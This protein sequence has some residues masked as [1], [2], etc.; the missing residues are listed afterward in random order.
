MNGALDSYLSRWQLSEPKPLARTFT[1]DL[2]TVLAADR[3]AVL[4]ILSEIGVE[5]E[6]VGADALQW[7]N[8]QGAVQLLNHDS[9]AMLLEFVSGDSLTQMVKEGHD[10]QA[11]RIIV[12]VLNR[13]HFANSS[14]PPTSLIPLSRR[15]QSLLEGGA[16]SQLDPIIQRGATVARSLLDDQ[17]PSHVLHGDIHHDNIRHHSQRGWLAIDPKGLMGDRTYDAANALC[18][19]ESLPELVESPERLLRQ[20]EIMATGLGIEQPRILAYTFAHACLSA[21]WSVEDGQD[22]SHAIL[23]ARVAESSIGRTSS[24]R[25]LQ[26]NRSFL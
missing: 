20:A 23:M 8:G 4:K 21:C 1:S 5:D 26:P 24:T 18:N 3:P 9:G 15:F 2:Y 6:R 22:P 13:L 11:T 14:E 10:D 25:T 12:D 17:R 19:P 16:A 7:Y